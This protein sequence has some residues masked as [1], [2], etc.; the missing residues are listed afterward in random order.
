[1]ALR[2][3]LITVILALFFL[4]DGFTQ[5]K[6]GPRLG[7]NFAT[8]T[9][10]AGSAEK[11]LKP[12]INAGAASLFEI[13]YNFVVQP[14]LIF[15]QKGLKLE[16]PGLESSTT[17][18]YLEARAPFFY[19]LPLFNRD[20][21]DLQVGAGPYVG[22]LLS[23]GDADLDKS[24]DIGPTISAAYLVNE[25]GPGT[26]VIQPALDIGLINLLDADANDSARNIAYSFSAI[27]LFNL[28][29]F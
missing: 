29:A 21:Y 18:N 10:D 28:D 25:V 20:K 26:I 4:S 22:V 6:I 27:Y 3:F 9:I 11:P 23:D 24:F 1:M 2:T 17:F 15:A 8:T 13:S 14:G 7:V 5:I 19:Q 16:G 12:G